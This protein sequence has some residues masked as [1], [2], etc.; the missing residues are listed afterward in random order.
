MN[1]IYVNHINEKIA[2]NKLER[3]LRRLFGRYGDIVLV[4]VHRNLKMKGQAFVTYED[5]KSSEKAMAKLQNYPLFRQ[6]I[7]ITWAK[8]ELDG[9][10][11]KQGKEDVVEERKKKKA[12][13]K[14]TVEKKAS[15]SKLTKS[16]VKY[17]RSLPAH[18]V[19]LLQNIDKELFDDLES[20][21]SGF[22]GYENV[23]A[24]P[25]RNLAFIDFESEEAATA[26]I[27]SL[28]TASLGTDVLLTY[29]K[30]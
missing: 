15:T 9:I 29:A 16:Q 21:F 5:P 27:S 7:S 25:S 20:K 30:K 2:R 26:C 17:W 8:T 14:E 19:L 24:I 10:L 11:L 1:T 23:R 28:E 4:T 22:S 12:E 6:P 13:K 18:R 3:V